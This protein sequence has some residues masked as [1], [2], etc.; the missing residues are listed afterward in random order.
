MKSNEKMK[1]LGKIPFQ[2][3]TKQKTN[4]E[5]NTTNSYKEYY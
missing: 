4:Q 1:A 5:Y 2:N 3:I